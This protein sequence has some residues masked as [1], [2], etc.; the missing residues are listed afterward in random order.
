MNDAL[1]LWD[2]E[3]DPEG[4]VQH[5][6][7]HGLTIEEVESAFRAPDAWTDES[8]SSGRP[9]TFGTTHTGRTIAVVW[10]EV[11]DNPLTIIVVT[12]YDVGE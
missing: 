10:E 7:A 11:V 4:N 3:D 2:L 8:W 9:I 12:A 6:A 1:F 5:V